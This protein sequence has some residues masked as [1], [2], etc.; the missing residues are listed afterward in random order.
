[1]YNCDIDVAHWPFC[2][3]KFCCERLMRSGHFL[4]SKGMKRT[5][6]NYDF[7][8]KTCLSVRIIQ[9]KRDCEHCNKA[10]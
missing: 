10:N 8:I 6:V 9:A 3:Y 4:F 2:T 7:S 5:E 1:M